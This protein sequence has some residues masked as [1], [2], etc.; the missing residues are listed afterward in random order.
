VTVTNHNGSRQVHVRAAPKRARTA[1][2]NPPA[3]HVHISITD[4]DGNVRGSATLSQGAAFQLRDEINAA[5]WDAG[6]YPG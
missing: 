6:E 1:A 2:K 3:D 4:K 5:I